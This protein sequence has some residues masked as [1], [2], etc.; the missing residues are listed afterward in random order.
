[1]V[2]GKGAVCL[3]ACV[4]VC[5]C[6]YVCAYARVRVCACVL[7]GK[8]VNRCM[9]VSAGYVLCLWGSFREVYLL[10]V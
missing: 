2:F 10:C 1:M 6:V 9:Y 3:C 7:L 4:F 8:E 5:V